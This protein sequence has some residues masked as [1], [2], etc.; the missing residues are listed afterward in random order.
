MKKKIL[1]LIAIALCICTCFAFASCDIL[2]P[3]DED[4]K[5]PS[6]QS[7][8]G[9]D[10]SDEKGNDDGGE[11]TPNYEVPSG[12]AEFH[13]IDVGQGDATLVKVGDK[14]I[15]IDTGEK[16]SDNKVLDYLNDCAVTKIEYFIVTHFDSDHFGY[17][18]KVLEEYD[19]INLIIPNQVKTTKMYETFMDKVEEQLDSGEI[20]VILANDIICE[21]IDVN[22]LEMV[23]LAPLKEKYSTSN[24][25][26]IALTLRYG[27][28]KVLI[29]GDGEEEAE[30]E[31]LKAHDASVLNCDVFKLGHHGSSTS[32]C[33][34]LFDKVTPE[35]VIISC[36]LDN[37]YGHPHKETLERIEGMI[38]YRT[39]LQGSILMSISNDVI[40]FKTEK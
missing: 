6:T 27:N 9:T 8:E 26:S 7:S 32:N 15:L 35:I 37:S 14:N 30:A 19:V 28:K 31:I 24:D 5:S 23:M 39:D 12:T 13:F 2:F 3:E 36:G 33:Q 10:L 17:A 4:N 22:G 29:T 18:T 25:Y 16:S 20:E 40:T 11:D 1:S 34:E 38:A 21:K